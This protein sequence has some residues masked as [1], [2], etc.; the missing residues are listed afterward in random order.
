MSQVVPHLKV[1]YNVVFAMLWLM[2]E[3]IHDTFSLLHLIIKIRPRIGNRTGGY[4]PHFCNEWFFVP[5]QHG[6]PCG[7][8]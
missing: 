4:R 5:H 8:T 2:D 3:L 6:H 7:H 1:P